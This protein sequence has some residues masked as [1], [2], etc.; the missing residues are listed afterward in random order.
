M[1]QPIDLDKET[2]A[3]IAANTAE[4]RRFHPQTS[5]EE[6]IMSHETVMEQRKKIDEL[7]NKMKSRNYSEGPRST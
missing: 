4:V 6:K 1:S 5:T 7:L 2:Y 3:K